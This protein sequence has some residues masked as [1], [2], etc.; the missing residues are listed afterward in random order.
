MRAEDLILANLPSEEAKAMT[1]KEIC[2]ALELEY[3][4]VARNL[5]NLRK[6]RLVNCRPDIVMIRGQRRGVF[7]WWKVTE[8]VD[9]AS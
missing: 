8:E 6:F 3:P 4:I 7:R 1:S 2:K 9:P 5:S